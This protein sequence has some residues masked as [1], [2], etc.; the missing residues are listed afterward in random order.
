MIMASSMSYPVYAI[1]ATT[2]FVPV[3]V[4]YVGEKV[5]KASQWGRVGRGEG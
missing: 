4:D 5:R 3:R 1:T 2:A